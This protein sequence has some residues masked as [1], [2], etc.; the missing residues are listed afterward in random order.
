ME[1]HADFVLRLLLQHHYSNLHRNVFEVCQ[2]AKKLSGMGKSGL[3][4]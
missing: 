4:P 1:I 2:A 3:Q